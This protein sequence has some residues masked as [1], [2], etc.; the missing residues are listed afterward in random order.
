[1][2][3]LAAPDGTQLVYDA[4]EPPQPRAAVLLLHDWSDHAGRWREVGERLRDARVAAYL[5]DQRGH[6]RSGG[7]RGYLSRFSQLLGDLQA[8]R[9]AVRLRTEGRQL[10]LG[11]GFGG[12]VTLRYLET[13]PSDPIAAAVV[14]CPWLGPALK[15][16]AWTRLAGRVLQ[17]LWPTLSVPLHLD[18]EQLSRDPAVN[19]AYG[20]D[21][22]VHDVMSPGAWREIRWAQGA[23]VADAQRIE[24]PLLFLLAGEDR[25]VDAH[26]GRAFADGLKGSADVRWYPEMYHEILHDPQR[27]RVIGDLLGFVDTQLAGV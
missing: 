23:V 4:Y 7:R 11:L 20:E 19:K 5:L 13:Q 6:G 12:L 21:P 3:T 14:C 16:P 18:P 8:F 26:L 2:P 17:D 27:E 1:M 15:A 10:L 9:R 24:S 22:A 25:V